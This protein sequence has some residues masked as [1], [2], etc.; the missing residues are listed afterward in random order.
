MKFKIS[1]HQLRVI[2][3]ETEIE[4]PNQT[5]EVSYKFD[6]KVQKIQRTL[7][8]KGYYIGKYGPNKDGVDGK[9]GPFTKA[10]HEAAIKGMDPNDFEKKRTEIAQ[11]FIGDIG[12]ETLKNE[13]NFHKIPDGKNN[14]RSAQIP[15]S[16]GERQF[17]GEVLDK[18]GIKRII[19]F[20]GDG[21]DS[22]H[23]SSHPQ[24]SIQDEEQMAKDKGIEF[25][26]L[27]STR[28]HDKVKS[29]L[30]QGNVL[31]HCA[32]GADRTGGNV[33]GYLKSIGFGDT[34]DI[35]KYTTQYNGWNSMVKNN[36]TKF[37]D[38][39]YLRQAQHFG[40]QDIEHA[41]KLAGLK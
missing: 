16:I 22:H 33:G 25:H 26:K 32:H 21:K 23:R 28:N 7:V 36:P 38:G 37:V 19:R 14:Y 12:D 4:L 34:D 20:N 2:T 27:S 13:F 6:P 5:L 40:V 18:Y 15:V 29:L 9:Y 24:T 35:W 1:L 11:K 10:A 8:D 31:I 30:N 17:L 3:E 41:K 39:G